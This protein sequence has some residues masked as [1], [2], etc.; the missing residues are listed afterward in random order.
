M[1][2]LVLGVFN[3]TL[4]EGPYMNIYQPGTLNETID[5]QIFESIKASCCVS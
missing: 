3:L 4:T 2:D 5:N 1:F